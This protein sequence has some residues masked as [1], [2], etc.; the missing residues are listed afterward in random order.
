MGR[1]SLDCRETPSVA[2]CTLRMEADAADELLEAAVQHA[3]AVHEHQ[4][5]DEL[6]QSLRAGMKQTV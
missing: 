2:G 3:I 6:R 5:S 1:Y 4:D